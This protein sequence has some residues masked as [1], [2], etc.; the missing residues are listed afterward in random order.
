MVSIGCIDKVLQLMSLS[1][2]AWVEYCNSDK[3]TYYA[4]MRRANGHEKP[5][6][7]KY[8]ALGNEVWGPW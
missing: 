4:N 6:A 5:Y 2:L 1:A 7:V 8:W 3:D